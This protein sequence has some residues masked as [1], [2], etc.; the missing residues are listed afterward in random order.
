MPN[1]CQISAN[2][3]QSIFRIAYMHV[4]YRGAD[5]NQKK[6]YKNAISKKLTN[7]TTGRRTRAYIK[8]Q[9]KK[10]A[11]HK[12]EVE[13]YGLLTNAYDASDQEEVD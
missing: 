7:R 4:Y 13:V 8:R 1:K 3:A 11:N 5:L 6:P 10:Q 12:V 9:Q 2:S